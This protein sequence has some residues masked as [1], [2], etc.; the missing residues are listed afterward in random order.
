MRRREDPYMTQ[1]DMAQQD[2]RTPDDTQSVEIL[3]S[4]LKEVGDVFDTLNRLRMRILGKTLEAPVRD[5]AIKD[6]AAAAPIIAHAYGRLIYLVD[7]GIGAK[8]GGVSELN[9][10]GAVVKLAAANISELAES[11]CCHEED[12]EW[13]IYVYLSSI[14]TRNQHDDDTLGAF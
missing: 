1:A 4:T 8:M 10:L 9:A 14:P 7:S 6:L 12:D 5:L 3:K 2:G 11:L 13:T